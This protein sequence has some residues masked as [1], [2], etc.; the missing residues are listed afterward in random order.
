MDLL[1]GKDIASFRV[2]GQ[3][4]QDSEADM[5]ITFKHNIT[6]VSSGSI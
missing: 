1:I 5:L 2:S 6:I 3:D 4:S